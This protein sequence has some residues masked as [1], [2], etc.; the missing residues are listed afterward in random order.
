MEDLYRLVDGKFIPIG[1]LVDKDYI[2]DGL[3]Y[4]GITPSGGRELVNMTYIS[5]SLSGLNLN[6]FNKYNTVK[7]A[8]KIMDSEDFKEKINHPI[9][10]N[11][12]VTFVVGKTYQLNK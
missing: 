11:D 3:W 6:T 5:K 9:S 4:V 10:I 2:Y 1:C 12:L 8:K 7:C